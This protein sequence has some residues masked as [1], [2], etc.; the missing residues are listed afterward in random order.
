MKDK[1]G[2]I[3]E[4]V[5]VIVEKVYYKH[6]KVQ[7]EVILSDNNREKELIILKVYNIRDYSNCKID[8]DSNMYL[9]VES[10]NIE[11]VLVW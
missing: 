4:S 8:I 6:V 3:K 2:N 10:N 1:E 11:L 9:L 7:V 5:K